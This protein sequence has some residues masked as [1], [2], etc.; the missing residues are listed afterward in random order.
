MADDTPSVAS[1]TSV[2]TSI[3]NAI[4][5][6]AGMTPSGGGP[7]LAA[8]QQAQTEINSWTPQP[9][10][11]E[12]EPDPAHPET[13]ADGDGP[14]DDGSQPM[15]PVQDVRSDEPSPPAG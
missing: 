4:M 9:A 6:L 7:A 3:I 14:P 11:V 12:A 15:E 5:H 8:L 13:E 10:P 1:H 2:L